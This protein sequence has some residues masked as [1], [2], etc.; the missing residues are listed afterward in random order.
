[1][2]LLS[3]NFVS[4]FCTISFNF[5]RLSRYC[6]MLLLCV[7]GVATAQTMT[8]T[9][10]VQGTSVVLNWSAVPSAAA[11]M[12]DRNGR[13][14]GSASNTV[15]T[16]TDNTI[17]LGQTYTYVVHP[18][19]ANGAGS[20][21]SSPVSIS[22]G[23]F[24]Y[25]TQAPSDFQHTLSDVNIPNLAGLT[26]VAIT[27]GSSSVS[28]G[29]FGYK[30]SIDA[31]PGINNHAPSLAISYNSRVGDGLLGVGWTLSG[32]SSIRRCA[33]T[34]AS[35]NDGISDP[36]SSTDDLCMDGQHLIL[37]G[38]INNHTVSRAAYWAAGA[39]YVT[40]LN[41]F[42]EITAQGTVAQGT[43]F[44]PDT[45]IV[46]TKNGETYYFGE[47]NRNSKIYLKDIYN[48][49][50]ES[51]F[52]TR[53]VDRYNNEYNIYYDYNEDTGEHLPNKIVYAPGAAIVFNYTFRVGQIPWGSKDRKLFR[54]PKVLE[55]ID[56]YIN[57]GNFDFPRDGTPVKRYLIDYKQSTNTDRSLVNA[58]SECGWLA[59]QWKCAKPIQFDYESS[60]FSVG[61]Y[62]HVAT[63]VVQM[64][65]IDGDEYVDAL[66][67]NGDIAWGQA[68]GQFVNGHWVSSHSA[69][70]PNRKVTSV[71][72]VRTSSGMAIMGLITEPYQ[73]DQ[74]IFFI[75]SINKNNQTKVET[76]LTQEDSTDAG[77]I[78]I[79]DDDCDN[80]D[81]LYYRGEWYRQA[82]HGFPTSWQINTQV[83]R[84]K[85]E[86][87]ITMVN[88]ANPCSIKEPI[89]SHANFD[90]T[91]LGN[92]PSVSYGA[93]FH[94]YKASEVTNTSKSTRYFH[95]LVDLNGDGYK[96][97]VVNRSLGASGTL[98]LKWMYRLGHQMFEM[99]AEQNL[100]GSDNA[101]KQCFTSAYDYDKDGRE[102]FL[103]AYNGVLQVFLARDVSGQSVRLSQPFPLPLTIYNQDVC[104][105]SSISNIF[106]G[107]AN[108]DGIVDFFSGGI[109]YPVTQKQP[110][111]L[112][113]I[114]DGF[115]A[116]IKI[117]YSTL[118]S[119]VYT[120]AS[121]KPQFPY[122]PASRN[123]WVVKTL[124]ATNG[125]GGYNNTHYRYQGAKTHLHGRGFLGFE[126]ITV[127][128][129]AKSVI[130]ITDYHQ[131]WPLIGKM[132]QQILQDTSGKLIS[133]KQNSYAANTGSGIFVYSQRQVQ[134]TFE[135]LTTSVDFPVSTQ[136][137]E[138]N[139]DACGNPLVQ[140]QRVGS[141]YANGVLTGELSRVE[142]VNTIDL[143]LPGCL[144]DFI[145]QTTVSY[146]A[147]G[148]TKITTTDFDK[149]TQG[150]IG[151]RTD[152][153]GTEIQR[154]TT[155]NRNANG[156]VTSISEAA[157][158]IGNTNAATRTTSF[159]TLES[160]AWPKRSLNALNQITNFGYD[161]RFGVVNSQSDLFTN[162]TTQY[163]ELGRAISIKSKDNTLTESISFYCAEISSLT[164]PSGAVYGVATRVT[165][166]GA[167]NYLGAPLS[168]V[169][170]D[171]LQREIRSVVYG[172]NGNTVN[173]AIEYNADGSVY[174]VSE[175]YMTYG[176][177]SGVFANAWTTYSGYDALGR[178]STVTP[179]AGGSVTTLREVYGAGIRT[180]QSTL[181]VSANSN[182]TQTSQ[183]ITNS[184]GQ[185]TR[186]I[187]AIGGFV[188]YTY[189][190]Q[191][192]LKT[193]I[194]NNT[195]STTV[196]VT[197]D[198]AGNKTFINDPDAKAIQFEY[199]GFGE[200]RRQTW[201]PNLPAAK[202]SLTFTYDNLGRKTQRVDT[203][204]G[205]SGNYSWTYDENNQPGMLTGRSGGGLT[206]TYVYNG[207]GQLQSTSHVLD[208]KTYNFGYQYDVFGRLKQNTSPNNYLATQREY[209][210]QG[211]QVRT[212]GK[213]GNNTPRVLW[214][215][216]KTQDNRG[217][218]IQ[219][220]LGN[221]VVTKRSIDAATGLTKQI[222]SGRLTSY[223]T[224]ANLS[225]DIQSLGFDYDSIGNLRY[226]ESKRTGMDG[227]TT[228]ENLTETLT[229]DNLNRLDTS[230][231]TGNSYGRNYDYDDLGNLIT[232][233]DK[234][235]SN[236]SNRDIGNLLYENVRN[237][238]PH[239]VTS[240]A[241]NTYSYDLYGNMTQRGTETVT[242][243]ILNKPTRI[244][245]TTTSDF[246]YDA[247][248]QLIKQI[249]NGVTTVYLGNVEIIL[250]GLTTT[251]STYIDGAIQY[252]YFN[253][254]VTGAGGEYHYLH[255]DH[256][257]S[258]EAI[259]NGAGYFKSRMSFDA[260]GNRRLDNWTR[261]TPTITSPTKQGYTGHE[262]L[263]QHK[264]VHM[265]GRV[266]DP[267][268][269]RFLSA[270]PYIQ[271][272]H[273]T[274]SYNRYSY[275][276]NNPL[277][278]IDPT[279]YRSTP[280]T[281]GRSGPVEEVV[282]T[283]YAPSSYEMNLSSQF[284]ISYS[285]AYLSMDLNQMIVDAYANVLF[286]QAK[287]N[288]WFAE[289][290]SLDARTGMVTSD[291][292]GDIAFWA[293][294]SGGGLEF[295]KGHVG[296][297][298]KNGLPSFY[299]KNFN[300]N[301]YTNT[302]LL[303]KI[304]KLLGYPAFVIGTSGNVLNIKHAKTPEEKKTAVL[305][306]AA[307]T[308][309]G[310]AALINPRAF[311]LPGF[312]YEVS[313]RYTPEI[314]GAVINTLLDAQS[315]GYQQPI[316]RSNSVLDAWEKS[317]PDCKQK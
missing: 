254:G 109:V 263:D 148:E 284:D 292:L 51:W 156:I 288:G 240:A 118:S 215:L 273:N 170:Y 283:G 266:Y 176:I 239:A 187:D 96:E 105:S 144:D 70:D 194:V 203:G 257:G 117:D 54:H 202:K 295:T 19:Y 208:G 94:N 108:N 309:V 9:A 78:S 88:W 64:A 125:Q 113:K 127:T 10:Q 289:G 298:T 178:P 15:T 110:D 114:T 60:A 99:D 175:P 23:S 316:D 34:I 286:E 136:V 166:V 86:A 121:V 211:F 229:Y 207:Y 134:K 190:A 293:G 149:N 216:G 308:S 246:V 116:E 75:H 72:L 196:S 44:E 305:N 112:T 115:G 186:S 252:R 268:L 251:T 189:D 265:Q 271:A 38:H 92:D 147:N 213:V 297:S 310:A 171:R 50:T 138:S 218:F 91:K 223:N 135:L 200:L 181:V 214:A 172:F 101:E 260:W 67:N 123:M 35:S 77:M 32:L 83:S 191:G 141:N 157:K 299:K 11:Y 18:Y 57:V 27:Q 36:G 154:T 8:V 201:Q 188:D 7:S 227:S 160:N 97:L 314:T 131:E 230:K 259:S 275:V 247:D 306:A 142:S 28:N 281:P 296:I 300:G 155:I 43:R 55:S 6:A 31:P 245:G 256:L 152:F 193:T 42:S 206:D 276:F 267:I 59:S 269:G 29:A 250:E 304:G 307:D 237:A 277:S 167:A 243:D 81:D 234:T 62:F 220:L 233:E 79:A 85:A 303:A 74:S 180:T 21:T 128:D 262:Q 287:S 272:P 264:L 302:Q 198:L 24:N 40:E 258:I 285:M 270:D 47:A 313:R 199:N 222:R 3:V 46:K 124:S 111:L 205:I 39:S 228:L 238:G 130:S 253:N 150:D 168:I 139:I 12:I 280:N 102:D 129:E 20:A 192:N 58:I 45:F 26:P 219:E 165:N 217:E 294:V 164:C 204:P 132:K 183:T 236:G 162:I 41:N 61:N 71:K 145:D 210:A 16:Y 17:Q 84:H 87:N 5:K 282:V 22:V 107:D 278:F 37:K 221:G 13:T 89:L 140:T 315:G 120:P 182:Q 317:C 161:K 98:P 312:S 235:R 184:L 244:T 100:V 95:T 249:V 53:V 52:L 159:D 103:A 104:G 177:Q 137:I 56:T 68:N 90:K 4:F 179:A 73:K 185:V 226:R 66:L 274:Q 242:Y 33:P 122:A 261:G 126:K 169:F 232:R 76:Y 158:D 290:S 248:H 2:R 279:G 119:E 143:G 30:V 255:R 93:W 195:A 153:L 80:L 225:G 241:G 69:D 151:G 65:D 49:G 82:E 146:T 301:Q 48:S 106:K 25:S 197:H 212:L 224:I 133:I 174:R 163:D 311:G 14:I 1:M 291:N 173:K 63:D 209:S 231:G